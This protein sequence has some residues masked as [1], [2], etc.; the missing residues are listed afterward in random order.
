[1]LVFRLVNKTRSS[2][3]PKIDKEEEKQE[4]EQEE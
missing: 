1:M 3:P 2:C 4:A